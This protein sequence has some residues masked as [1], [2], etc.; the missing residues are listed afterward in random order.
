MTTKTPAIKSGFALLDVTKGRAAL[1]K[2]L[3]TNP[4]VRFPVTIAGYVSRRWGNDDGESIE[5][6][7]DVTSVEL[8][9]AEAI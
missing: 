9:A 6:E 3:G 5:F 2:A 7:V 8:Q 4:A 1:S